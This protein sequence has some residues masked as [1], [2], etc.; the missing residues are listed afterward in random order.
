MTLLRVE[1]LS[2]S[3][4]RREGLKRIPFHA[5]D[6]VSFELGEGQCLGLIGE[7]GSGKSTISRIIA[8]LQR[9]DSGNV[10]FDGKSV[11]DL[12][13]RAFAASPMRADIQIVFQDP[14]TSLNPSFTV[15]RCIADPLKHLKSLSRTDQE[16]RVQET[17]K[18][19][20]L[21]EDFL[22]RRP[23]QLSGGQKARV[24]I[25]RAIATS[26]RLLIL[27]E[28]TA[29]LDVSVQA[30][31]MQLLDEL[32]TRLRM[33]Y[34]FVSHD[35]DIIRLFSDRIAVMQKGKLIEEGA[36]RQVLDAPIQTYTKT[37]LSF[38]HRRKG[39]H[40]RPAQPAHA[41]ETALPPTAKVG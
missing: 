20:G 12:S 19:V 26:P 9:P 15:R 33:S 24:G 28:P 40:A 37:L 23:H 14:D 16:K 13:P 2:L 30:T 11:T 8:G 7:S 36:L 34:L 25:A 27:D 38:S 31:I 32:R 5:V 18:L 17:M 6:D 3:Y 29:A 22:D 21:H 10:I 41:G 4:I 1:N 39:G 35:L